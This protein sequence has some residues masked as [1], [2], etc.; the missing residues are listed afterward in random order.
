MRPKRSGECG[1]KKGA[2]L[3]ALLR[4]LFATK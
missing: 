3:R 1:R 2:G 4:V